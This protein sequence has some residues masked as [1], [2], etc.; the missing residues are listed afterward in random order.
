MFEDN[1]FGKLLLLAGGVM[2]VLFLIFGSPRRN[3]NQNNAPPP[4]P[5][6]STV[7]EKKWFSD[8]KVE[9]WNN[10]QM[11]L[12]SDNQLNLFPGQIVN[13]SG[14]SACTIITSTVTINDTTNNNMQGQR[15]QGD[16]SVYVSPID[17]FRF[18]ID[19]TKHMTAAGTCE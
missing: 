11:R 3:D 1:F 8:N 4:A 6:V 9:K 17:G 13:C 19:P 12:L 15:V 16:Q 2:L 18:C 5:S 7:T 14:Q 10:N